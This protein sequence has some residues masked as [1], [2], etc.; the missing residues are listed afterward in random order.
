[1]GDSILGIKSLIQLLRGLDLLFIVQMVSTVQLNVKSLLVIDKQLLELIF[2][3]T[4]SHFLHSFDS[5]L[6]GIEERILIYNMGPVILLF[7]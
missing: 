5:S 7:L 2:K 3:L 4:Y 1:M 6:I